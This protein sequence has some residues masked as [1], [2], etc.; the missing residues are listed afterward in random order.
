MVNLAE[1]WAWEPLSHRPLPLHPDKGQEAV[2]GAPDLGGLRFAE[3]TSFSSLPSVTGGFFAALLLCVTKDPPMH[4]S[5][6][7]SNSAL[8]TCF[9]HTGC[10]GGAPVTRHIC[11]GRI[12]ACSQVALTHG[13][14]A[15]GCRGPGVQMAQPWGGQT[16]RNRGL[17]E[18][19]LV[20]DHP[21]CLIGRRPE[22][23]L[24]PPGGQSP[25]SPS[26]LLPGLTPL[27]QCSLLPQTSSSTQNGRLSPCAGIWAP[28]AGSLPA[29]RGPGGGYLLNH[30]RDVTEAWHPAAIQVGRQGS[31]LRLPVLTLS[32]AVSQRGLAQPQQD[33]EAAPGSSRT[34]A[35]FFPLRAWLDAPVPYSPD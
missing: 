35:K 12:W 32:L 22:I 3:S 18:A 1:Q 21:S 33:K 30:R 10:W 9:G 4:S 31:R 8:V 28:Y 14:N 26:T 5:A 6:V 29:Q 2:Q 34:L 23:W 17:G 15:E 20:R 24:V 25:I 7:F 11:A 19:K 16:R 13:G 27:P